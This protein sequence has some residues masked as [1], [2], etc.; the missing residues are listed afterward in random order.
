MATNDCP[1]L[2]S[3]LER[4]SMNNDRGAIYIAT[5]EK[6]TALAAKSAQ[7]L[8]THCRELPAHIFSDCDTGSYG[9]FD[10]STKISDPHSRS[11]VDYIFK[12]PF[13]RTLYL[14]SDT[15]ICEDI[16]HMFE[17]LDHYEIA[18]AYS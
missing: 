6:Y 12:S 9:V 3:A 16:I 1:S 17:L 8:K 15:W 11:K 13:Q 14:D 2:R 7:S 5:G 18:L 4:N 10:S